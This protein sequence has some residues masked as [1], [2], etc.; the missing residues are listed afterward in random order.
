MSRR[1]RCID[2]KRHVRSTSFGSM[3][4][5]QYYRSFRFGNVV[6]VHQKPDRRSFRSASIGLMHQ[7]RN[8][9]SF[10][11]GTKRCNIQDGPKVTGQSFIANKF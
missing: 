2:C 9:H 7:E 11:F 6:A 8:H 1:F 5:E 10:E 3:R 4:Q